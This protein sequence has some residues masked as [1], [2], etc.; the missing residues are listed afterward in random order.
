MSRFSADVDPYPLF[1]AA[2][3]W[4]DQGLQKDGSVF[5]G[6]L[7]WSLKH[8][9]EL[10]KYY[11]D[12]PDVS[13]ESFLKIL[14]K[15][16]APTTTEAKQLAAEMMW[17]MLLCP[18]NITPE[19][20]RQEVTEIWNWSE[21]P[22]PADLQW[23]NVSYLKGIGS[24][25][26]SFNFGRWREL[27]FF[28]KLMIGFKRLTQD[29]RVHLLGNGWELA[30]WLTGIPEER[31]RQFRH[32]LLFL[33]FPDQFERIFVGKDRRDIVR[34]FTTQPIE[35]IDSL[36]LLELDRAVLEIRKAQEVK[37]GTKEL[38]FYVPP[39]HGVWKTR[40]FG[41]FTKDISHEHVIKA[42]E[43]IDRDGVS[44]D[45]RSTTY[46]LIYGQRRYPP[47]LVLSLASK[48]A[49]GEEF[50]RSLFSGGEM[51]RAFGLLRRLGFHIER[52]DFVEVL[53]K[54]FVKQAEAAD[55]LTTRS[56][57][58]SYRGLQLAVSFGQGNFAKIPWISFLGY[59]QKTSDGIYPVFL[60]YQDV[61]VL[62]LAYGISETT[63]PSQKWQDTGDAPTIKEFLSSKFKKNA[64]RY[65][66]SLV[67][68]AYQI[69]EDIKG[70]TLTADLDR[71]IAAY[72][73]H[74]EGKT[75]ETGRVRQRV[76]VVE[77]P[78]NPAIPS[79]Y[80]IEDAL[81][82][83]FMGRERFVAMLDLWERKKNIIV[84][85]PPG[86][87]KTFVCRRLA[88]ALLREEARDRVATVQFHQT[89]AYEDFVQGYRPTATGFGLRDG[90]FYQFCERA[91]DDERC[92][93]VFIIDEINRGN[94]SKIFGELLMLIEGDKRTAEW[95]VPLAYSLNPDKKFHIPPNLYL[96]GL[97]NTAD[98]SLAM[99]DYALRRRFAFADLVPQFESEGFAELLSEAGAPKDLID[100]I[101]VRMGKLNDAIAKDV[102]N[103][104]PGFCIGRSF[105]CEI[106]KNRPPD[107]H[108]YRSVIESDI[109]PLLRE[110]WFDDRRTAD[111]WE[112]ALLVD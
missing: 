19:K 25:G 53:L 48:Y 62:I 10:E 82:G 49:S 13:G 77:A 12:N 100:K 9:E 37:Y 29:K 44:P 68:S 71:V 98:R 64:E 26:L 78:D 112:K 18:S 47:K 31:S 110:Y 45:A 20:K 11:V 76:E 67:F 81:K 97:M 57:P 14:Q 72:I 5:T 83:L 103:L 59:G 2:E 41:D 75:P 1:Q 79:P 87:G 55:D 58:K 23:L 42:I 28:V 15:Q 54:Q 16:L 99:V 80:K 89:Y 104:G 109:I 24:A 69:P 21:Q 56:Y 92:K 90:L 96:L 32:M 86:V 46:D 3:H 70:E 101:A 4:R 34:G 60:L 91:R 102:N 35:E 22:L 85:G 111:V 40:G 107:Q 84:Q 33:L 74:F 27:A 6:K 8:F 17:V 61:S 43:E 106:P 94:L 38:D 52:K 36:R 63:S 7:L 95:G 51:S 108:W 30:E 66:T 105:F 73:D 93:Y 50:D 39:L 65:G 88:Y